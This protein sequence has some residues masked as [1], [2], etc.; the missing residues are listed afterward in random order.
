MAVSVRI[1]SPLRKLTDGQPV[2]EAEGK[3]VSEVFLDLDTRY[4]GLRERLYDNG[5]LRQFL[6]VYV[7]DEDIRFLGGE[8]TAV[9]A[10]DNLSIIP[11]IA[12]G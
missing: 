7:N 6:N 12:G 5:A 10:G 9:E 2:L 3:P 1:P 4:P 8:E 11:A